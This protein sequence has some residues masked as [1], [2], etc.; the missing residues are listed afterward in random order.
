MATSLWRPEGNVP[1]IPG[2]G[3]G[4][5]GAPSAQ[6]LGANLCWKCARQQSP[7][8]TLDTGP[9]SSVLG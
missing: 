6:S 3:D 9:E 5:L 7:K 8:L 1:R 4:C 2:P